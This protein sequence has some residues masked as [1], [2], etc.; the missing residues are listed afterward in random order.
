M[1]RNRVDPS[2]PQMV[3]AHSYDI[4][5]VES[6]AD[7]RCIVHSVRETIVYAV[8]WN[9]FGFVQSL[10]RPMWHTMAHRLTFVSVIRSIVRDVI[11]FDSLEMGDVDIV[12][13]VI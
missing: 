10:K 9:A 4:G 13:A 2:L 12:L 8:I 7:C 6:D 5:I 3:P 1:W 11:D